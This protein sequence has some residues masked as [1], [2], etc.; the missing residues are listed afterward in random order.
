MATAGA[1]II[2]VSVTLWLLNVAVSARV[3]APVTTGD[4]WNLKETGQFTREWAWFEERLE[5]RR[6]RTTSDVGDD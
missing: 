1:A 6:R 3:G 2:G 4:P 5:E